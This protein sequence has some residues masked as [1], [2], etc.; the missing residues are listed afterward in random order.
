LWQALFEERLVGKTLI[1]SSYR[2]N[3]MLDYC[4][5]GLIHEHHSLKID[6]DLE[7]CV[8]RYPSRPSREEFGAGE[9]I[10]ENDGTDERSDDD[11]AF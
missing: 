4:A 9:F 3:Q 7:R 1:L 8:E 6:D 5:K 2:Q 10:G 11:D